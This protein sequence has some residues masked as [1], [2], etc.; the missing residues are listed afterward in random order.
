VRTSNWS[1]RGFEMCALHVK[2]PLHSWIISIESFNFW[3]LVISWCQL[4][5][6]DGPNKLY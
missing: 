1:K 6:W 2:N 5:S 4:R 3:G